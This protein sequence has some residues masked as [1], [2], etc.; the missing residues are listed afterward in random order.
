MISFLQ[1]VV[2]LT[3]LPLVPFFYRVL[4]VL[5][6][7]FFDIGV[8][9]IHKFCKAV[10]G[11]PSPLPGDILNLPCLGLTLSVSS[12]ST[13]TFHTCPCLQCIDINF[14]ANVQNDNV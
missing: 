11:W 2:I 5:A 3:R 7:T 1:S 13:S 9:V 6:P 14:Q 8:E 10:D 12:L 4:D